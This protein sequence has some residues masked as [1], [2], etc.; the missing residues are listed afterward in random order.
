MLI[1]TLRFYV[2]VPEF[3]SWLHCQVHLLASGPSVS[4]RWWLRY[5]I[6]FTRVEVA[7]RLL[8]HNFFL[9]QVCQLWT[10]GEPVYEKPVSSFTHVSLF[11]FAFKQINKTLRIYPRARKILKP[12]VSSL[13]IDK[14]YSCLNYT[15]LILEF[16]KI[17]SN[18]WKGQHRRWSFARNYH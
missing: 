11:V 1:W 5:L 2:Q 8:E 18:L 17:Y 4:G 9:F 15:I 10:F 7:A 6:H 14:I 3:K 13:S 12:L 16:L